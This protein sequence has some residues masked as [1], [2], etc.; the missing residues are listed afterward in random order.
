MN[1][2]NRTEK[3]KYLN[4]TKASPKFVVL[5]LKIYWTDPM[6]KNEYKII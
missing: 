3:I 1:F 5:G 2:A 6:L 4:I